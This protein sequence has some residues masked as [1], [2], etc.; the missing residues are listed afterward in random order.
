VVVI[1]VSQF[2][3]KLAIRVLQL[4]SVSDVLTYILLMKAME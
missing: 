3:G 1:Y 2:Y 4:P